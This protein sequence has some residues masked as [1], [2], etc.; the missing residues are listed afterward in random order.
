MSR[1]FFVLS[2][3]AIGAAAVGAAVIGLGYSAAP[4]QALSLWSWSF[5]S[6]TNGASGTFT[7]TDVSDPSNPVGTFDVTQFT[8]STFRGNSVSAQDTSLRFS[9]K[10][11]YT[12]ATNYGFINSFLG[13]F[14]DSGTQFWD[15]GVGSYFLSGSA[16]YEA[17]LPPNRRRPNFVNYFGGGSA[18]QNPAD[19]QVSLIS[20]TPPPIPTPALLPGLVGMGVAALRKKSK[21]E[22]SQQEAEAIE[23]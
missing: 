12:T 1:R 15:G 8:L 10:F 18:I 5:G 14:P 4:A 17:S 19:L 20:P 13:G 2:I 11:V 9:P 23:A 3:K 21:S 7:T 16:A 6:G 22:Q